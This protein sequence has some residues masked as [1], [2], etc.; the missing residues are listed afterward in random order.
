MT[1]LELAIQAH[2]GSGLWGCWH[3]MAC[4]ELIVDQPIITLEVLDA[5]FD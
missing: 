2:G 3:R 1:M 5:A 4:D